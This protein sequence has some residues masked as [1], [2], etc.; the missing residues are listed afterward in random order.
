M[1]ARALRTLAAVLLL[2]L[3]GCA[4]E[5]ERAQPALWRVEGPQGER[6][7]LF[8]TIHSLKRPARWRS[9]AVDRAL[10]ESDRV[11]VEVADL[12][13]TQALQRTFA[14]LAHSPGLPPLS[15]RVPPELRQSLAETLARAGARESHF[16]GV[17]TWAA[18]LTLA[19]AGESA[20]DAANGID[21]AVLAAAGGRPVVELE[22]AAAQL[23]IFDR[24]PEKEQQDLLVAVLRDAASL[25]GEDEDL[26]AAW[27]KGDMARIEAETREG[28]LAD[29]E[30]REALFT[31]RNHAWSA[32]LAEMLA[33]GDK[34]FVAVGAA[35]MAGPEGLPALLAERGYK[36]TRVQ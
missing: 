17:E 19:R 31:A 10:G 32:R 12:A 30:L 25:A 20:N 26:A 18:A 33:R 28:L 24:L 35:H 5:P 9:P 2:A 15:A 16:A 4:S 3:T 1:P 23:G 13:D 36:V 27:R 34:P 14:A 29:P 7:H 6:G 8:G 11:V 21:R 22:G